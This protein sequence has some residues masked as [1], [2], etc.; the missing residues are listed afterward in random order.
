[1][2]CKIIVA[3]PEIKKLIYYLCSFTSINKQLPHSPIHS[4]AF[5]D[6][7]NLEYISRPIVFRMTT[8]A[9]NMFRTVVITIKS[10]KL[11]K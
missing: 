10:N 1:M 3:C 5:P 2:D 4:F 8:M 7:Q 9:E 6:A 11:F